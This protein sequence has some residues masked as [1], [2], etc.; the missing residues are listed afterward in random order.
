M[1]IYNKNHINN[2]NKV[3]KIKDILVDLDNIEVK[4]KD[5]IKNEKELINHLIELQ[6]ES[7]NYYLE[8]L[9]NTNTY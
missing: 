4:L 5:K 9:R 6:K 2:T 1:D 8:I 3:N 7:F